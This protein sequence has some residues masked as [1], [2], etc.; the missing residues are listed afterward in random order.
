MVVA[1]DVHS[2]A[3]SHPGPA[4]PLP[5]TSLWVAMS[6][7]FFAAHSEQ[8]QCHYSGV[9]SLV[10]STRNIAGSWAAW[11]LVLGPSAFPVNVREL[12]TATCGTRGTPFH[13]CGPLHIGRRRHRLTRFPFLPPSSC[14]A[15]C[16]CPSPASL[17][18]DIQRAA[19]QAPEM[20]VAP[21]PCLPA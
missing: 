16:L 19:S 12:S 6:R 1:F 17:Q 20:Q 5:E 14:W 13:C 4:L 21:K 10:C 8:L 3:P 2:W 9:T 11:V 7:F 15:F 18:K